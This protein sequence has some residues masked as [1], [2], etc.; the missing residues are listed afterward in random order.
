MKKIRIGLMS[1]LTAALLAACGGGDAPIPG[2]G[3]P[4]GAPTTR[5]SFTAVVS[6]GD[7]LSD[8]GSYAAATVHP[9]GPPPANTIGGKFTTNVD[10]NLGTLWVENLATA[11]GLTVTLAEAGFNKASVKCPIAAAVPA[12]A[13]TCTA[14]GQGGS[15]ITD[16]KGYGQNPDGSG[17]LA[18]PVVTQIA[19]HLARFGSFKDSDLILVWA[20]DNDLFRQLDDFKTA[21]TKISADAALNHSP[22]DE[23]NRQLFSAQTAA[24]LAMKKAAQDLS[25][26]VRSQILAKG[27]KYV[28]VVTPVDIAVTP[29]GLSLTPA[30]RAFATTLTNTFNLW[31]RDGLTDQPV[32]WIDSTA[33]LRDISS[34]PANYGLVNVTAPAC[35]IAK[36][37]ALTGGAVAD[38]NSLFCNTTPGAAYNSLVTGADANTW[39][40]ADSVHPTTGGHKAISDLFTRQLKSF[41]WL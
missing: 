40:F 12:L 3:A 38:G 35:D 22:A 36:I 34:N 28:A 14:Y 5:G 25:G 17:M 31:L 32:L 33:M 27:G 13:S 29:Y 26:Y 37:S 19:N 21:A 11:L 39:L 41:G 30:S 24:Q 10:G 1:V 8:I 9:F 2:S 7:S 16:T 23:V 20:G 18:V 4:S 6:F 15:R